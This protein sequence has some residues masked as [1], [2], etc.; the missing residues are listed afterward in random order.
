V[1]YEDGVD[2]RVDCGGR[3]RICDFKVDDLVGK[4]FLEARDALEKVSSCFVLRIRDGEDGD[5]GERM[6]EKGFQMGWEFA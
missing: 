4:P 6:L 5:L 1:A 3:R 2:R